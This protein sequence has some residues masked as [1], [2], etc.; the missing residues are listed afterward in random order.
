MKN[1]QQF[2]L[3]ALVVLAVMG[4]VSATC[5]DNAAAVNE[6]LKLKKAGINDETI[7][8]FVKSKNVN[9][10]LSSESIL[11]LRDQGLSSAVLT[12]MLGSGRDVSSPVA[13]LTPGPVSAQPV[14]AQP[15]LVV[16][17]AVV[18]LPAANP[19]V[20]FFYQEL[21]PYGRW[22]LGE[23]SQWYWQPTVAI[24]D[25]NWRP[26]WDKG[27]WVYTDHG[28]YWA[29]DYSW[30]WAAFHYGRWHMHPHHGWVWLPDRVWGPAWVTWRTGGE[31]CG[32]A[33]LP[34]GAVYDSVGAHFVFQGKAVG[35]GF[36]FGLGW[37]H[38]SYCYVRD[39]GES[40]R[41]RVH[42]EAELRTLFTRTT[43]VNHYS[44]NRVVVGGESR[45]Q[46][47]N[48]GIDMARVNL[49]KGHPIEVLKIN[50]LQTPMPNRGHERMDIHAKTLEVYRPRLAPP[51]ERH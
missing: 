32:W 42:K 3:L 10:D 43:I 27:R 11:S 28:W 4:I 47:V 8:A 46:V 33:P 1:M 7:V 31:Y 18:A 15:Q 20:A 38:F 9:Y 50:D 39:M 19:D 6:V 26:Y 51:H 5:A 12:A 45:I 49:A 36:D 17:P 23:D 16:P 48:H 13:P 37:N 22:I 14:T 29:S 40:L 44:V 21:S 41:V 30:G 24:T 25:H 2:R 35:L 34:P